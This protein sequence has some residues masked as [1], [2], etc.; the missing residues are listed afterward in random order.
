MNGYIAILALS[1]SVLGLFLIFDVL[2]GTGSFTGSVLLVVG[3]T[4]L[5]CQSMI[6]EG[7]TLPRK[8]RS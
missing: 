3:G 4:V 2:P 8:V 1:A 5:I 7:R 6:W